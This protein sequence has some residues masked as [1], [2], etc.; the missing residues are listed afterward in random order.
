MA[1]EKLII[2][3]YTVPNGFGGAAV[4][5]AC[6]LIHES[7]GIS[8]QTV[9]RETIQFSELNASTAS[10]IVT[11]AKGPVGFLWERSRNG[12]FCC[13]P[14][15]FTKQL[16]GT[17]TEAWK[18]AW[19]QEVHSSAKRI[20]TVKV[21]DLVRFEPDYFGEINHGQ[22]KYDPTMGLLIGFSYM[23]KKFDSL[24][25]IFS[26]ID[27]NA[28]RKRQIIFADILFDGGVTHSYLR[29]IRAA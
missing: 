1:K 3:G 25:A 6:E 24:D 5:R 29:H 26:S 23:D 21:G 27:M 18:K 2:N 8:Q 22:D 17:A 20:V 4:R 19:Y 11:P 13:Y 14:N 12:I 7:P 28:Q 15:E 9:L 16:V 10:W